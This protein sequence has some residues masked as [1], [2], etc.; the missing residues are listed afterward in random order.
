MFSN[1]SVYEVLL[2]VFKGQVIF[3]GKFGHERKR[4]PTL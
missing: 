2:V 3:L 4:C 1:R